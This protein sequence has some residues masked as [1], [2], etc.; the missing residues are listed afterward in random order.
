MSGRSSREREIARGG[1]RGVPH[2]VARGVTMLEAFMAKAVDQ[3]WPVMQAYPGMALSLISVGVALGAVA[4]WWLRSRMTQDRIETLRERVGVAQEKA[5]VA[6]RHKAHAENQ[7]FELNTR[8]TAVSKQLSVITL[9]FN[10][11]QKQI[12]NNAPMASLTSTSGSISSHI[13]SLGEANTALA[14]AI[15]SLNL[16][17]LPHN[18]KE[19]DDNLG[20]LPSHLYYYGRNPETPK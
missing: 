18:T 1:R 19:S 12:N 3:W 20:I 14:E 11:L 10:T 7:L 4:G 5:D 9:S 16:G 2:T 8:H 6:D 13:V 17:I 15:S